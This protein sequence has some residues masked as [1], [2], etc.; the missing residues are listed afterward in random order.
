MRV[1]RTFRGLKLVATGVVCLLVLLG[2]SPVHASSANISHS[3]ESNTTLEKGSI[4]SLNQTQSDYVDAADLTNDT[5]LLGIVVASNDSLLAVDAGKEKVQVATSGTAS[6]LVSTVNGAIKV[7]DQVAASPFK[8]IG[9]KALPGS[10]II[11]LAQTNFDEN[12]AGA[13][14][15]TVT[16]KNGHENQIEVG[17]IRLTIGIGT[18]TTSGS[19]A[20]LNS[21]QRLA[22]GLTGKTISTVR[23]VISLIIAIVAL[24]ALI[25][26][27]YSSIYGS[28]ISIGRNPLAKYAVFRTLGSVLGMAVLTAGIAS[29]TIFLLLR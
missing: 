24:I 26:L 4:V 9:M 27:I 13:T 21:L 20:N 8:G 6:T 2:L 14:T 3:Y 19:E 15:Q 5:R 7:G 29:V 10:H 1:L 18:D 16:D 11:G 22:K 28:I 25:T 12:S 23:V 17:F